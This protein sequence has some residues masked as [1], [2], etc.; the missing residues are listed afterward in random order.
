MKLILKSSSVVIFWWAYVVMKCFVSVNPFKGSELTPFVC[1]FSYYNIMNE[2]FLSHF[3][4]HPFNGMGAV[5]TPQ[6]M[7]SL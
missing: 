2:A 7:E 1:L 3:K 5:P 6:L 4:F